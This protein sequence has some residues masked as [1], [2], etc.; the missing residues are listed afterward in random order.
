VLGIVDMDI[1]FTF[2]GAGRAGSSHDMSVSRDCMEFP[3][4]PHPPPGILILYLHSICKCGNRVL[5]NGGYDFWC[6]RRYYLVDSRYAVHN[7]QKGVRS[8]LGNDPPPRA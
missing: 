4:Y 2:V 3:N 6:T 8:S 7:V 5:T 1:R